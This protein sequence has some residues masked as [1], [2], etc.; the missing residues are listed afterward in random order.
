MSDITIS[1]TFTP[2]DIEVLRNIK[3]KFGYKVDET[4]IIAHIIT[5]YETKESA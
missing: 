4:G 3:E 2:D 5:E 1:I